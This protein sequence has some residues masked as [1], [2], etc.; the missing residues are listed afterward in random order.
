MLIE[1]NNSCNH[2]CIFCAN[3]KIGYIEKSFLIR[4]LT[5]TFKAGV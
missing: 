1:I 3:K 4:I 2:R 5:E